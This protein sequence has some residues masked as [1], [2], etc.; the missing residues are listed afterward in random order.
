[1]DGR[2][3]SLANGEAI[4]SDAVISATSWRHPYKLIFD[5]S[6]ARDLRILMPKDAQPAP[7]RQH[8]EHRNAE[9]EKEVIATTLSS[10]TP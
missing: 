5:P 7:Y 8:W 6:L 10:E 1:M 2:T 4:T 3:L 9:A